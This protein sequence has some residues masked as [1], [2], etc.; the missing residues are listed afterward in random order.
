MAECAEPDI[1]QRGIIPVGFLA[2][3]DVPTFVGSCR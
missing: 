3:R 1:D 2:F